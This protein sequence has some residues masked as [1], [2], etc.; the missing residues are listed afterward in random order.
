[1]KK[2][3]E[4]RVMERES[5]DGNEGSESGCNMNGLLQ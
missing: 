2:E 4:E 3:R 5:S 1:M